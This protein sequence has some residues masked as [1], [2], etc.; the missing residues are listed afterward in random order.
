MLLDNVLLSVELKKDADVLTKG[1]V[2]EKREGYPPN[3]I[4]GKIISIEKK[5][6]DLFQR[7]SVKSPVDF[8]NLEYVFILK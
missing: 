4:V 3:L 8:K 6:S 1:D 2:N 7:A 5:Q